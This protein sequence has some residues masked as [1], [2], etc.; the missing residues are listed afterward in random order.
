[1]RKTYSQEERA[2]IRERALSV[3]ATNGWS[4]IEAG[5]ALG[6]SANT[7]RRMRDNGTRWASLADQTI[8]RLVEGLDRLWSQ[9]SRIAPAAEPEPQPEPGPTDLVPVTRHTG[10]L[11]ERTYEGRAAYTLQDVADGLTVHFSTV[12]RRWEEMRDEFRPGEDVVCIFANGREQPLFLR[13]GVM[14]LAM[15]IGGERAKAIRIHLRDLDNAHAT[16][17]LQA[18]ATELDRLAAMTN[19]IAV[20]LTGAVVEAKA[21]ADEAK[22]LAEEAKALA[23]A[24]AADAEKVTQEAANILRWEQARAAKLRP[25]LEAMCKRYGELREAN[26]YGQKVNETIALNRTLK[27]TYGK[28]D[29]LTVQQLER[30]MAFVQ[31]LIDDMPDPERG[32]GVMP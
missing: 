21:T 15:S 20:M 14:L 7:L 1:M 4:W 6:V 19:Q 12:W 17:Q 27:S 30:A 31:S 26:G 28:R 10:M 2:A 29:L 24:N 5:H 3:I 23:T 13:P 32:M 11:N 9:L 18:P 8:T 25:R 16:G 22:Q